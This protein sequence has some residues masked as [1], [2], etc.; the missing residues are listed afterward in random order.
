MPD[1]ARKLPQPGRHASHEPRRSVED[2]V[3]R[4][5]LA[6]GGPPLMVVVLPETLLQI[7]VRAQNGGV[8]GARNNSSW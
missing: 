4:P 2:R 6:A 1:H 8:A 3:R 5:A 7:V